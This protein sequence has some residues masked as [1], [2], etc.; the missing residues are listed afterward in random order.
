[1]K[2]FL[3]NDPNK[4]ISI[5]CGELVH[6]KSLEYAISNI[7]GE[8]KR[9]PRKWINR[10]IKYEFIRK[11]RNHEYKII[12]DGHESLDIKQE[13]DKQHSKDFDDMIEGYDKK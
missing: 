5:S 11:S 13:H 3:W 4:P 2:T 9:T 1:M 7:R 8:D 6:E 10:L 12:N